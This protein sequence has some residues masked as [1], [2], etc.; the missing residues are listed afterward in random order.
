MIRTTET[1]LT[2][3]G[4]TLD[5]L[6]ANEAAAIASRS[7]FRII[8]IDLSAVHQA[9]T[10]AFAMLI[11]LRG[12]LR[13]MGRDLQ[14]KGIRDKALALYSLMRLQQVLPVI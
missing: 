1:G 6:E 3:M 11:D 13:R 12:R 2:F 5:F 9:T 14:L 10:A 7:E 4:D 8:C